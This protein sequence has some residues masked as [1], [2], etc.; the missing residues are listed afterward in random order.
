MRPR[1]GSI[2]SRASERPSDVKRR[3]GSRAVRVEGAQLLQELHAV[4]DAAGV[5]R[6]DEREGRDVAQAE[7]R[8][9]EDDR[10]QVGP[11]DL[12]LGELGTAG[13]SSSAYSRMQMPGAT[14]PQ[15]P[16]RWSA[17]AREIASI[18][19]RWTLRR[20]LKREMRAVPAS[21]T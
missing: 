20:R 19:S 11:E 13:E 12:R 4:G 15:R 2:G 21:T 17:E 8:H 9:L 16:A 7:C 6:V 3:S 18:G 10:G 1:R 14:R 5:G